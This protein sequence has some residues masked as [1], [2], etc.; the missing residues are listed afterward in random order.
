MREEEREGGESERERER[1]SVCERERERERE[2]ENGIT[3]HTCRL[4]AVEVV[5]VSVY[6]KLD[7]TKHVWND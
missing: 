3:K 2:R 1:E 5:L 6:A 4:V 7:Q